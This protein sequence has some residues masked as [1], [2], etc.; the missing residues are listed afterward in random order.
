MVSFA[1]AR[2]STQ[3]EANDAVSTE[4]SARITE[5]LAELWFV[6]FGD[7]SRHA[8]YDRSV[9]RISRYPGLFRCYIDGGTLVGTQRLHHR[10]WRAAR[11]GRAVGG[12]LWPQAV[13]LVGVA[14][15]TL[16]S[17][18]CGFAVSA[19]ALIAFRVL[20]AVGGALLTPASLALILAA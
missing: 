17:V 3:E 16:A 5:S 1:S 4:R 13:F 20:Q 18:L 14:L 7:V 8:G 9:C 12:S 19:L 6:Q 10:V 15:F 2:P 11:S